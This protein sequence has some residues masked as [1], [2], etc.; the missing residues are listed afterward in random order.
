M[1]LVYAEHAHA[2]QPGSLD[3][4]EL[5]ARLEGIPTL[6]DKFD[7]VELALNQLALL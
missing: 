3:L 1:L 7:A 2:R 5:R 4:G 6:Q